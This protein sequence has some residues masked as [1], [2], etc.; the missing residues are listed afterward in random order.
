MC[1]V[2][3][4]HPLFQETTNSLCGEETDRRAPGGNPEQR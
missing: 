3:I 4:R 1:P 2:V